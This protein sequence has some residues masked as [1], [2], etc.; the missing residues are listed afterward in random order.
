MTLPATPAQHILGAL[1]DCLL[2]HRAR[3]ALLPDLFA[4]EEACLVAA[5]AGD[6]GA[7][8]ELVQL[9]S[10]LVQTSG[11]L[12]RW[13]AFVAVLHLYRPSLDARMD[14]P[15]RDLP[16]EI[17][18]EVVRAVWPADSRGLI[19]GF[20]GDMAEIRALL[21]RGGRRPG[22]D[23]PETVTIYRG[24]QEVH[25]GSLATDLAYA[26]GGPCWTLCPD[27]A[28]WHAMDRSRRPLGSPVVF[29]ARVPRCAILHVEF[30]GGESEVV[31]ADVQDFEEWGTHSEW[32]AGA[33]R[34]ERRIGE[35]R[36]AEAGTAA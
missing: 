27:V 28:C 16:D 25:R 19:R 34:H 17:I 3:R 8:R 5:V 2:A 20:F 15:K 21:R 6:A 30:G 10:G 13:P 9:P 29:R 7:A 22:D 12:D 35:L 31:P 11:T 4:R 14:R 23:L 1:R 24:A 32:V 18:Q 26:A 36:L 33:E